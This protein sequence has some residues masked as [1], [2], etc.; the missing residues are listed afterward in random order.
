M[1]DKNNIPLL[2]RSLALVYMT[3]A[4]ALMSCGDNFN[5][6]PPTTLLIDSSR[7]GQ[8]IHL[9]VGHGNIDLQAGLPRAVIPEAAV[10]GSF[11]VGSWQSPRVARSQYEFA[12]F[13]YLVERTCQ[14]LPQGD[15]LTASYELYDAAGN[16]VKRDAMQVNVQTCPRPSFAE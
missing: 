14:T 5:T 13:S 8:P 7:E 6:P 10:E 1:F 15:N 16:I 4:A 9:S 11:M 2:T 12:R 3:L